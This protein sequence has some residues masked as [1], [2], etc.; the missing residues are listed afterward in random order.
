VPERGHQ[1]QGGQ[2]PPGLG[3][4]AALRPLQRHG[5]ALLPSPPIDG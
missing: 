4:L 5:P 1:A 2:H 3:D